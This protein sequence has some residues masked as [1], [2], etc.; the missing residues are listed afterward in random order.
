MNESK[1]YIIVIIFIKCPRARKSEG[2]GS[3]WKVK[4]TGSQVQDSL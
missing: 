2:G 3:P 4:A 1:K